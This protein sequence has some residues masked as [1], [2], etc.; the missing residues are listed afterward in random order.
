MGLNIRAAA[1]AI[2]GRH[3]TL[4]FGLRELYRA[5][6]G[7]TEP[8]FALLDQLVDSRR[9]AIDVGA[10]VG[11]YSYRLSQLCPETVAIEPHP[12]LASELRRMLPAKV[13]VV[14]A[15]ASDRAGEVLLRIPDA[16]FIST[17]LATVERANT[18]GGA[19]ER[20]VTVPCIR[21]DDLDV[22][23]V[24]FIKIDVEGHELAVLNG[25]LSLIARCRPNLLV[26]A[27]DRHRPGAATSVVALMRSLDYEGFMLGRR[28][29]VAPIAAFDPSLHQALTPPDLAALDHG[30]APPSY[31]TNFIFIPRENADAWTARS[32]PPASGP[33]IKDLPG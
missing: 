27:E 16:G 26:E 1:R 11:A 20:S 18:L 5:V 12:D 4:W 31:V 3:P 9:P 23:D 14:Q 29:N 13:K 8:E 22:A 28:R 15:A 2:L 25:A 33:E 24:G 30:Q 7:R 32:A 17:G 19:T 6:R 21:L 10:N